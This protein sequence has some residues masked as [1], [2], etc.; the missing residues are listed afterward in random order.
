M[1]QMG[2]KKVAY[3]SDAMGIPVANSIDVRR[4][5]EVSGLRHK[6]LALKS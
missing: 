5:G 3:L 6:I 2:E 1:D 4:W